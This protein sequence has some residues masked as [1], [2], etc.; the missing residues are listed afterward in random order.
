MR[1]NQLV[2]TGQRVATTDSGR[3]HDFWGTADTHFTCSAPSSTK[4]PVRA[5][6]DGRD[7]AIGLQ[8]LT[9][10]IPNITHLFPDRPLR[11][12]GSSSGH[13]S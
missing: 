6:K 2:L 3:P 1:E 5:T 7:N 8:G 10:P 12:N 4:F 13:S 9:P 11:V